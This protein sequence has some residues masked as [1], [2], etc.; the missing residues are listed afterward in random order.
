[1]AEQPTHPEPDPQQHP[2]SEA[3]LE[4]VAGG[5]NPETDYCTAHGSYWP[6][7]GTVGTHT[8]IKSSVLP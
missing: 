1:M 4:Q 7:S 3:E 6:C 2:M 5:G 8:W